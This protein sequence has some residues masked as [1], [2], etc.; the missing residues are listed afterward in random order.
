ME[1]GGREG[2]RG[3]RARGGGGGVGR[4]ASPSS[5][6]VLCPAPLVSAREGG[7]GGCWCGGAL[8]LEGSGVRRRSARLRNLAEMWAWLVSAWAGCRRCEGNGDDDVG[9]RRN[10][11]AAAG[12]AGLS[13]PISRYCCL[14]CQPLS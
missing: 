13:R 10:C 11:R 9:V 4:L 8:L 7:D 2:G 1:A 14:C 12:S 6:G 5:P 3:G